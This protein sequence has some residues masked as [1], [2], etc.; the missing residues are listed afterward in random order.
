MVRVR[1]AFAAAAAA[2]VVLSAPF[3]QQLFNV[4][5]ATTSGSQFRIIAASATAVPA[6]AAL[7]YALTRIRH[8]HAL[9]YGLLASAVALGAGY[10]VVNALGPTETFHFVEY[11]VL[12]LL[13]Y[14]TWR[15]LDDVSLLVLPV[16]VGTITGTLD[17]WFQ[18]FIPMRAGEARDIVL[19]VVASVCGLLFVVSVD[20]P[21]RLDL[22]LHRRSRMQVGL[23]SLACAAVFA[24]FFLTVHVGYEVV[25][26]EIGSFRSRYSAEALANAAQDRAARWRATPPRVQRWLGREDQYLTEALWHVS[27]R[28]EA[29]DGGD[30]AA[31]WRENRILEKF[32]APVL[33]SPTYAD[34]AGHRWPDSQRA[35][36]AGR[37]SGKDIAA[38]SDAYRYPL[39]VWSRSTAQSTP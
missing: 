11:G 7:L 14:R 29:W 33:D 12:G 20:P 1:L 19:N 37:T 5:S 34:S 15:S 2:A 21:Q 17:E 31:A 27:R 18:W 8:R 26:P 13:F 24:G 10:V 4:L 25:D 23:W 39:Y 22:R 36:A 3:L 28:N 16:V 9:R 32:Y 38:V 35:D 6:G 30:A